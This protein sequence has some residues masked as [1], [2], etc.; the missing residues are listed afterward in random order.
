MLVIVIGASSIFEYMF[1]MVNQ[2]LL[3]ADQKA[4]VNTLLHIFSIVFNTALSMI[5][6]KCGYNL[7]IVKLF[8]SF[9]FI[10][11]PIFLNIYVKK[12]YKIDDTV[13]PNAAVLS[14]RNAAL[15]KSIAYYIHT[16]TDTLVISLCMNAK[17]VSVYSVH[18]YVVGS[19]SNLVSSILGN[20]ESIFGQMLANNDKTAIQKELPIYDIISKMLST[21]FFV[22]CFILIFGFVKLYTEGVSDINYI[23]PVF[24]TFLCIAEYVYCTGIIYNNMIMGAGHLEQTK[25]IS[26]SEALI[27]ICLSFILVSKIGII[28]VS[29]GTLVA[30]IFANIANIVYMRRNIYK[31]SLTLIIKSYLSNIIAGVI[32]IIIFNKLISFTFQNYLVFAIYGLFVT[33]VTFALVFVINFLFFKRE[34]KIM[35]NMF[36]KK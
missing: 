11:K 4:Y 25:W 26:I 10:I 36:L 12:N 13:N 24:A 19:I 14:Q 17:W 28:G 34:F 15:A 20:T 32:T 23:Q 5:F 29:I 6:I 8:S 16:S 1:G 35:K 3:F 22:P 9:I 30:F 27:N 21:V 31:M 2:L 18:R 33:L 7:V